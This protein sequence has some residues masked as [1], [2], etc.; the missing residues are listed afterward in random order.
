M[1]DRTAADSPAHGVSGDDMASALFAQLILQQSNLALILLGR[2]PNPETGQATPNL[3]GARMLIDQ[4]EMIETKTRGNLTKDEE[5]LLRQTL[6][7]LR[8]AFVEAVEKQPAAKAGAGESSSAA[9]AT[10][11]SGAPAAEAPPAAEESHK[12]FS[13]KY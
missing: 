5:A 9:A 10:P 6:M 4:L 3:E 2:T 7:G 13:K 1:S 12:K 11:S 8:M